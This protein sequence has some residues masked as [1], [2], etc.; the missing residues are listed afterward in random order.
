[1]KHKWACIVNPVAGNSYAQKNLDEI[2]RQIKIIDN[3]APIVITERPGHATKIAQDLI[4]KGYNTIL[5]AGGDGTVHEVGSVLVGEEHAAMGIISS[6]TGNDYNFMAGFP[7][8]FEEKHWKILK[9]RKITEFDVGLCNGQYFF[10][11][12]GVGF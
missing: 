10:N 5:V 1:M 3:D 8:R 9:K 12:M 7:D 2:S 6:G 4:Q 11:G